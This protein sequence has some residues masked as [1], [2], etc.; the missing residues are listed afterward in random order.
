[1][2]LGSGC[3]GCAEDGALGEGG[4][5]PVGG[6]RGRF[7]SGRNQRNYAVGRGLMLDRIIA[8]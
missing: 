8:D 1:M 6:D 7:D 4:R 2:G 3:L 5:Q